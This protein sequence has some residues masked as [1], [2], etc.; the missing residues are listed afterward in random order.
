MPTKSIIR[1]ALEEQTYADS[2]IAHEPATDCPERISGLRELI[3]ETNYIHD[4]NLFWRRTLETFLD[5][6]R[7][8]SEH[9]WG[10]V[11]GD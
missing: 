11:I 2:N 10:I 8:G 5:G 6:T 1:I 7:D 3:G 4:N 9:S